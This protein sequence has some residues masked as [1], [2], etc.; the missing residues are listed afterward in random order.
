[1]TFT[2]WFMLP[3]QSDD[4]IRYVA[5]GTAAHMHLSRNGTG[6]W[7]R[8]PPTTT[9]GTFSERHVCVCD[10][11][12]RRGATMAWWVVWAAFESSNGSFELHFNLSPRW[13]LNPRLLRVWT[14]CR[15]GK[16]PWN[17]S[18]CWNY[19]EWSVSLSCSSFDWEKVTYMS[20]TSSFRRCF[21][22]FVWT[23]L[24]F[25]II[26]EGV[27]SFDCDAQTVDVVF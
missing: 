23:C 24:C 17:C 9:T 8:G 7:L 1:M 15:C 21:W 12:V 27:V 11:A 6:S 26:A 16:T 13:A 5:Y 3:C 4:I 20:F 25:Q 18:R 10:V 19:T 14:W 22:T 2:V